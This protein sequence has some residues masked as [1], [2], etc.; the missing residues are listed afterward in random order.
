MCGVKIAPGD[1]GTRNIP[2]TVTSL[3]DGQTQPASS[4]LE[5]GLLDS[6]RSREVE[7]VL[8]ARRRAA[9]REEK[10]RK[11]EERKEDGNAKFRRGDF[12]GAAECYREAAVVDAPRPVYLSNLAAALLKLEL[13]DVAQSAASRALY[14]DPKHP[15]ARFRRAVA[16]KHLKRYYG[17][18]TDFPSRGE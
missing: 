4:E 18:K 6:G 12:R 3:R 16:R 14:H 15:K 8:R 2:E 1:L 17:A 10:R 13:W 9:V 11:A 5:I 7:L